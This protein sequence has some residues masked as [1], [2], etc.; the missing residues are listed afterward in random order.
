MRIRQHLFATLGGL[1]SLML[2]VAAGLAFAL[3][4]TFRVDH[5]WL[6]PLVILIGAGVYLGGIG[7]TFRALHRTSDRRNHW[8][9]RGLWALLLLIQIL[10]A[11]HWVAAPRADLYFV[12]QQALDLLHGNHQWAPYFQT[13]PNN[14]NLTI[15]L[16]GLL[17]LGQTFFGEHT[18][19]WLNV[20]Q[21]AWLDLSLWASWRQLKRLN[22]V[23]ANL[24]LMI[25]LGTVPL[26]AYALN[27][28]S[29][30]YVLPLVLLSLVAFRRLQDAIT[31]PQITGWSIILGLIVT[32]A[33]L[34]KANF[35]VLIIAVVLALLLLKNRAPQPNITRSLAILILLASLATGTSLMRS[36]QH[37]Q[38]YHTNGAALPP[39]SWIAMSWNPDLYGQYNRTDATQIIK[40]PT[41]A[42]KK[43]QA[44]QNL[45]DSLHRLGVTGIVGHL[46]K[47]AQ[48]FLA[49]GTFDAFQISPE[50][51]R[52][53]NWYRQHRATS[54]W[55]LANWCQ[56]NYLALLIVNLGWGIQQ[57]RRRRISASFLLGGLFILGLA[58][59]HI[60]F[61]ETEERYALPILPL[62]I[63]GTA[64]GY[65]QPLNLFRKSDQLRWLPLGMG[66]AFTLILGVAAWQNTGLI[67]HSNSEPV[68]VISQGEGRYYQNHHY[69]LLPHQKVSQPF[70]ASLPFDQFVINNGESVA[71]KITLTNAQGKTVWQTH[72]DQIDLLG[73]IPL[74]P[75]GRYT[76]TVQNTGAQPFRLISAPA[77]YA[78]LPQG[79]RQH[80][81]QYLR[82]FIQQRSIAPVLSHGKFWLLFGA[83]WLG[84]LLIIDRFY[85]YRRQI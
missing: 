73:T 65:R 56:M 11:V 33:Y 10:V 3:P 72:D 13:Y 85:W 24:F 49:T 6:S 77:N 40:Q 51:D 83:L 28:Y 76:I 9:G 34:L 2:F 54:D 18:G 1:I 5:D 69:R 37:Q 19:V 41:Q 78:L 47:K 59:F 84:G 50:F 7:L 22:I 58:A 52:A 61:W 53:P 17:G 31:W 43:A 21:F 35:I 75:A 64:A 42:A 80:P 81:H 48:L 79:I 12:H 74:Q 20:I 32:S 46:F 30:T 68:S 8:I 60:I 4:V 27:T 26:Y 16:S 70:T 71:G 14:V 39:V 45:T 25:I 38:G 15:L 67:S 62:L 82:F 36:V 55:F 57:L 23:R 29:D 66:V 63:A 44:K